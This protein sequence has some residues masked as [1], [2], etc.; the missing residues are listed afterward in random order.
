MNLVL[1]LSAVTYRL[2]AND[3]RNAAD[4]VYTMYLQSVQALE[5]R[6]ASDIPCCQLA[7]GLVE[8]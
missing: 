5:P 7:L 3:A 1:K 4:H 2:Y 8:G 6:P